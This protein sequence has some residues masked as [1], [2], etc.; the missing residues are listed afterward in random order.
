MRSW[1]PPARTRDGSLARTS[2]ATAP[3]LAAMTTVAIGADHAGYELKQHLIDKL[4]TAG[5]DIID[6]GRFSTESVDYPEF[7]SAAGRSVRDGDAD[8]GM[9]GGGPGRG[10]GV[11]RTR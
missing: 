3:R 2:S 11:A 6:Q 4:S 8:G 1:P 5:Y 9:G 10:G 7:C